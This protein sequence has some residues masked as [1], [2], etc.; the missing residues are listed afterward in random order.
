IEL[1]WIAHLQDFTMRHDGDAV[2]QHHG[3]HLVMGHVEN[4]NSQLAYQFLDL[5]AHLFSEPRIEVAQRFVHQQQLGI[6]CQCAGKSHPLLL[7]TA[8]QSRRTF[9]EVIELYQT[10]SMPDA[11]SGLVLRK[12][13]WT[14][15]QY[16]ADIF[17]DGHVRPDRVGLKHHA[18]FPLLR[19]EVT[20]RTGRKDGFV[21]ESDA[22]R[23]G[24]LQSRDAAHQRGLPRTAG[25]QQN[26][27]LLF[28]NL[29][30][31]AVQGRYRLFARFEVLAQTGDGNHSASSRRLLRPTSRYSKTA[32]N[33]KPRITRLAA[34]A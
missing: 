30:I 32:G 19:R 33:M 7:A 28:A 11:F 10:K 1:V 18:D 34:A 9:L 4:G 6:D 8:Q 31:D 23:I 5:R 14:V 20:S 26:K 13:R 12:P 24:L 21:V 2:G 29:K 17:G 25:S 27:E 3:F 15:R 22:S 16:Q